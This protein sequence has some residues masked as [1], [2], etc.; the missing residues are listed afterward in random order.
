[1]SLRVRSA[2]E[3]AEFYGKLLG[4]EKTLRHD[5]PGG[6]VIY[7]LAQDESST[8]LEVI[9]DGRPISSPGDNVHLGFSCSQMNQV[10]DEIVKLG[11][12]I[13][14]GPLTIGRETMLFLRDPD[15]Y[16]IEINNNL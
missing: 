4:F 2:E 8:I 11:L 15:G 6:G 13:D 7:H 1:V 10:L 9:Q 16:L 12:D 5:V 3:S 14:R